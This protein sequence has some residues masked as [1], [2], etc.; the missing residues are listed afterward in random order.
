MDPLESTIRRYCSKH[1]SCADTIEGVRRWWLADLTV[2]FVALERVLRRLVTLGV[3]ECQVL[4][5]GTTIYLHR[6]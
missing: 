5:D 3:L 4:P 1:P 2:P 6:A